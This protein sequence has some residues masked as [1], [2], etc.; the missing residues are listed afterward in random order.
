MM[1]LNQLLRV[2]PGGSIP[3]RQWLFYIWCG[4]AYV[5]LLSPLVIV[6]GAS[7]HRGS[8]YTVVQFPPTDLSL[9]WYTQIPDAHWHALMLSFGLALLSA[10][11][12][13]C[14]GIPAAL[15]LIRSRIPGKALISA[16]LRA[17]MQIPT[18]VTGLAFLQMYYL[19]GDITGL[20]VNGTFTGLFLAHLFVGIPYVVGTVVAVLQRFDT[21]L[22]EAALSLGATRWST[23]R[24]VT[25]PVILPGVYAGGLYAF[26]VS[27]GDVPISMLLSAP[28]FVTYP[29][30]LFYG[31]E[32][33]FNPAVL[34]SSTL[35]IF[36]SLA[37]MLAMQRLIGLESLLRSGG[38]RN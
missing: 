7:L 34:A 23:F 25:L 28:G 29:V 2:L 32:N 31:L 22:E 12:A 38:N 6:A 20:Y 16:I 9:Y 5:F 37:V 10:F 18:I 36:I 4:F 24:R 26:M 30:E 14:I 35:V 27:F 3:L 33:D 13:C 11:C 8:R 1:K 21:R 19:F 15:G 17:P